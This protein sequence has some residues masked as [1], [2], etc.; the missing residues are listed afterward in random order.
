MA[1]ELKGLKST[2]W[3]VMSKDGMGGSSE[4][5]AGEGGVGAGAEEGA[6][7]RVGML[8][9]S[10]TGSRGWSRRSGKEGSAGRG[11]TAGIGEYLSGTGGAPSSS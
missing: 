5:S 2:D 9:T 6:V 10:S 1:W 4:D 11:E 8:A 7:A 3:V